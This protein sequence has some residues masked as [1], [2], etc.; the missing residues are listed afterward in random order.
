[1]LRT[2]VLAGLLVVAAEA[3]SDSC[4]PL[5][6][7][8]TADPSTFEVGAYRVRL[9][10]PDKPAAPTIWEGP[11]LITRPD[12]AVPC[13]IDPQTLLLAPLAAFQ[14]GL[15]VLPTFSGSN[16]RILTLD[17]G[18][19]VIRH[20]SAPMT[21]SVTWQDGAIHAAGR[22]VPHLPCS[23]ATPSDAATP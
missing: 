20:V 10:H 7:R 14:G 3:R 8:P 9:Y 15:L 13:Q 17:M 21:G 2:L 18:L 19:C 12:A 4:H 1:M 6:M 11:I 23:R 5:P 22:P 16:M